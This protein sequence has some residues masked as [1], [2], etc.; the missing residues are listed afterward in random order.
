MHLV[1]TVQV[2]V[3]EDTVG[4]AVG[5]GIDRHVRREVAVVGIGAL[6]VLAQSGLYIE[7]ARAVVVTQQEHADLDGKAARVKASEGEAVVGGEIVEL[8][9]IVGTGGLGV[10]DSV[11]S[12]TATGLHLDLVKLAVEGGESSFLLSSD[13]GVSIVGKESGLFGHVALVIVVLACEDGIEEIALD[14][15]LG[16][17]FLVEASTCL[18]AFQLAVTD[19]FLVS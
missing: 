7:K 15:E 2:D 19:V 3:L 8:V 13:R 4:R 14:V 12:T 10:V 9:G 11:T 6:Q 1:L 18:E 5:L 16:P 17:G